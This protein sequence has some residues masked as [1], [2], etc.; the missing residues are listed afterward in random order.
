MEPCA[1]D[2]QPVVAEV[3]E[4]A[5]LAAVDSGTALAREPEQ[6]DRLRALED[7]ILSR[8]LTCLDDVARWADIDPTASEPPPEWVEELGGDKVAL[9]RRLRVAKA[10]WMSAKEAPVA[11][12][13]AQSVVVGIA[14]ARATEKG[15]TTM[16]LQQV[17]FNAPVYDVVDVAG[18]DE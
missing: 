3:V 11:I 14:K 4:T 7:N 10:A 17:I 1:A 5:P 12:K 2:S 16:N 9:A 18:A 8:G 13:V 15:G 6:F